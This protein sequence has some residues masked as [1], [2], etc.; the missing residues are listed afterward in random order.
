MLFM[1]SSPV[2]RFFKIL[3]VTVLIIFPI[4]I[5]A[6]AG[7]FWF[8]MDKPASSSENIKVEIIVGPGD[9]ISD[10]SEKL[11]SA[12]LVSSGLYIEYRFKVQA[13]LGLT[14]AMQAGRYSIPSGLKPSEILRILTSPTGADKVH[15][16][17]VIPPGLSS[18]A[19]AVRVEEAGLARAS[20]FLDAV[21]DLSEDF[22]IL[23]LRSNPQGLQGYLFPD[24][25]KIEAPLDQNVETSVKTAEMIVRTMA[26][27]FFDVQD[28]VFPAWRQ[29]T[30]T[31]LHEKVTLASIVE[32]EYRRPEEAP[33]IAAVFN[34]RVSEGM[35]LQSCAT[36][37][38]TIEDTDSGRPF[39]NEYYKF[40]RRIFERYLDIPSPYNTYRN[41]G[42]PPGP[43]SSPGRV[44]LDAVYF[45]A[46][47]NALF[48][49]V[50]DPVAGTHTFTR[51]YSDH[52]D[53]RAD[54]LNQYVVKE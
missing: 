40:N 32:R 53:A 4:L 7:V 35:P 42:L 5:A 17:L 31:Q 19:I 51:D 20:D 47:I 21:I 33:M 23:P 54:Y 27:K 28:E 9:T 41:E 15:V 29:L 46:D 11:T 22:P 38:Y 45:P 52:L 30:K 49:V 16:N 43:I 34:N 25:Y 12:R 18:R 26:Q 50:K 13:R 10:V 2:V 24:T 37:V 3:F 14:E 39:L 48:F 36:V 44:A 6:A 8:G 1:S